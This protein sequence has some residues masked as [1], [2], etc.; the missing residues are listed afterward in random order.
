MFRKLLLKLLL[1]FPTFILVA[2]ISCSNTK[3]FDNNQNN[4]LQKEEP[5]ITI[6]AELNNLKTELAS[7]QIEIESKTI[8]VSALEQRKSSLSN[9]LSEKDQKLNN[10]ENKIKEYDAKLLESQ[11][12]LNTVEYPIA[13]M[14]S[15]NEIVTFTSP[16]NRIIA[17]DSSA[18][19]ILFDI[20]E[21]KRI[22]GTHSFATHPEAV[23]SIPK[24][25]DAFNIDLEAIVALEP[26]LVFVFYQ[27]NATPLRNLGLKVLYIKTLDHNF[28]KTTDLIKMW[29]HITNNLEGANKSITQFNQDIESITQKIDSTEVGP[30]I[31][32][33]VG[34][35]WTPG[36][37]TLVNEVFSLLKANNIAKEID[38]YAQISPEIIVE[39]NP[40]IIITPNP[41]IF[42]NN[43]A[44]KNVSAVKND[45]VYSI[46][47]DSLSVPGPRFP[48]GI[49]EIANIIYPN[50]FDSTENK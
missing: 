28:E 42:L 2:S 46:E 25:G 32:Q 19:E 38:G 21:S 23:E 36:S 5:S 7:K 40:Q 34:G 35:L 9:E 30:K 41:E 45:K 22:V 43:Q 11:K 31:F 8:Q 4:S 26:D 50:I 10:L 6:N 47:S 13:I 24:V 16:P 29:G 39:K 15:D 27:S 49:R 33:D 37:N 17:F 44:Y 1:I 3:T 20:G 48:S 18:V 12:Q 14:S